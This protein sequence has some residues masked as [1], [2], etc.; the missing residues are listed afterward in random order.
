MR[1]PNSNAHRATVAEKPNISAITARRNGH[2]RWLR[3]I[4]RS[5]AAA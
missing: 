4:M 5:G 3:A 1:L 2:D